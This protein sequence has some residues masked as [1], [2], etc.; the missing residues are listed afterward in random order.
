MTTLNNRIINII[1][2]LFNVEKN[3][4]NVKMGPGDIPLWDSVGHLRLILELEKEFNISINVDELINLNN[5]QDIV[6]LIPKNGGLIGT[7]EDKISKVICN[8]LIFPPNI[9]YGNNAI[10]KLTIKEVTDAAIIISESNY[11]TKI[12]E[13]INIEYKNCKIKV[14]RKEPGEPNE[15]I[16]N[17]ITEFLNIVNPANIIAIGGGSTIDAAKIAR[18]IHENEK[19]ELKNVESKLYDGDFIYNT[20]LIAIPTIFGSG[21]EAS[22]AAAFTKKGDTMKTII[23]NHNFIP[24]IILL[25]YDLMVGVDKKVVYSCIFDALSHAIEGYASIINQPM[26]NDLNLN[27]IKD[28]LSLLEQYSN[29]QIDSFIEKLST[30]A[31]YSS[32]IQN[33][34]SVG[35][36]HSI[37]HQLNNYGISHGAANANLLGKVIKLNYNS[38]EAYDRILTKLNLNNINELVELVDGYKETA[39]ISF[40]ED[41]LT[42]IKKDS[43]YISECAMR[44]ITYKT[45]P[46]RCN[47]EEIRLLIESI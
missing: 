35:L 46:Y 6:N 12:L 40:D 9:R 31:Y 24:N 38:T 21:S 20:N 44:D 3:D 4:V 36:C 43:K 5:I 37:S 47:S 22:S 2:N 1:C 39:G 16:I 26:L 11:A 13:K 33:N 27:I 18:F 30:T 42:Q 14:Y 28:I 41:T 32:V 8:E 45:N 34:C 23:V 17:D 15:N 7:Q 10:S 25:D 29:G 19:V